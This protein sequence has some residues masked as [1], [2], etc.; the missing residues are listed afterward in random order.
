MD[1]N[2]FEDICKRLDECK[3]CCTRNEINCVKY[4]LKDEIKGNKNE[5]LRM[6]A[7]CKDGGFN[8]F[9]TFCIALI[10]MVISIYSMILDFSMNITEKNKNVLF[11]VSLISILIPSIYAIYLLKSI[12]KRRYIKKWR[13]YISIVLEDMENNW[14]EYFELDYQHLT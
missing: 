9:S 3:K 6:K 1:G 2:K 5:F 14:K 7:E 13:A 12:T 8:E 10:A 4:I 11:I